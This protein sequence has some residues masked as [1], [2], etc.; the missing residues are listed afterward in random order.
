MLNFIDQY[1][2]L[3]RQIYILAISRAAVSMGVMFVFPFLS[4]LLTSRLGYTEAQAGLWIVLASV[5]S[6]L[7]TLAG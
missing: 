5:I 3:P 6:I 2:G 7:G 4:L 1:R